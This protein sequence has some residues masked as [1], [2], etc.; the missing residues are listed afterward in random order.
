[1][2]QISKSF[3]QIDGVNYS[4]KLLL[5]PFD[6]GYG[7]EISMVYDWAFGVSGVDAYSW[8]V[9]T[10]TAGA[11]IGERWTLIFRTNMFE[12]DGDLQT[13]LDQFAVLGVGNYTL[14]YVYHA[15]AILWVAGKSVGDLRDYM[16][17]LPSPLGGEAIALAPNSDPPP[18]VG[19]FMIHI[20]RHYSGSKTLLRI[21][22]VDYNDRMLFVFGVQGADGYTLTN[23]NDSVPFVSGNESYDWACV[24]ITGG[25]HVGE[26]WTLLCNTDTI[27][28][29][30]DLQDFLNQHPSVGVGNYTI[31]YEFL[32]GD[33]NVFANGENEDYTFSLP[34]VAEFASGSSPTNRGYLDY[35]SGGGGGDIG[36]SSVDVIYFEDATRYIGGD[37]E[38][39]DIGLRMTMFFQVIV[40][41]SS[42]FGEGSENDDFIDKAGY[43]A[44]FPLLEW[45]RE[46]DFVIGYSS[47]A[48][49][50]RKLKRRS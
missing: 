2:Y 7:Q 47:S 40:D 27:H 49:L 25:E 46:Q 12:T 4:D 13:F 23:G 30:T 6:I 19:G 11:H 41:P 14:D 17:N 39:D 5:M 48:K 20:N 44:Y 3:L 50:I 31:D 21:G 26:K 32:G 1:M 10:V 45:L 18:S 34:G 29:T 28:D 37:E 42:V 36:I 22:G 43:F 33:D 8:A 16:F 15:A 9:L 38:D 35:S 24:S